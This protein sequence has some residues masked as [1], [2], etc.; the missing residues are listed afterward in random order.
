[1]T[2]PSYPHDFYGDDFIKAPIEHYRAMREMGAVLW[3]PH[4]KAY[5][6]PKYEEVVQALRAPLVFSSGR[7]LSLNDEVNA[8][9]VGSTLNSDPPRHTKSRGVTAVPIMP[10]SLKPLE[11]YIESQADALAERLIEM[12]CFDAVRDFAQV[13][14]LTI[15]TDLIGLSVA[16]KDKMLGWASATFNLFEGFNERSQAAFGDLV[17]LQAFLSEHGRPEAL[18]A[19]GLARRIFEVAPEHG[20]DQAEAAQLMRDYINPS[21]DTTISALGFAAYYFA[22][23]PD[24]WDVL[25]AEPDLVPNAIEEVVRMAT[26]I[27]AFSRYIVENVDI[28]GVTLPKDARVIVIYASAN[29]DPGM[30]ENPDQF[31]VRRAN[32]KHV[33]FG[34]GV[35]SCMGMHLA[36]RE[37]INLVE[38]MLPRVTRWN[39]T[40]EPTIA[41]NNTI[42][43][44]ETLPMQVDLA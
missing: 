44:F 29:R 24:Q 6:L 26:P 8:R 19:G 18:K 4:Q 23:F 28:G 43:A 42:R 41:M 12:G 40:A 21:L 7:G 9:L 17:D 34:H 13:L 1:M 36:R 14:P 35:H 38:A 20:F 2:T 32:R 16:G 3:L 10:R 31:D 25:R 15:V 22:K 11:E 37:M 39:I 27:R 30:F 5:A 33:G